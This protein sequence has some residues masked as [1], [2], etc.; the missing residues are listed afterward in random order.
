MANQKI[1]KILIFGHSNIGDIC[2]DLVVV[3]PLRI[4]F[5][6]AKISFVTSPKGMDIANTIK[7]IDQV[8]IFDKHGK[9]KGLFGYL[10][11]VGLIRKYKFDLAII[12]RGMQMHYFLGIPQSIKFKKKSRS[13]KDM[14]IAEKYLK[15]LECLGIKIEK[16]EFEFKFSKNDLEYVKQVDNEYKVDSG[17]R[18]G[19]MPLAAWPLKC[20]PIENWNEL[21]EKLVGQMNAKIFLLGRTGSSEWD[22]QIKHKISDKAVSLID[23]DNV[24]QA[25]AFIK[26]LDIFIAPDTSLL[27][28]AS[29]MGIETIG[30]Y[31]ATEV[32]FFYPLFHKQ[33]ILRSK[34]DLACMPCYPGPNAGSCHANQPAKCMQAI[35]P[36]AVWDKINEIIQRRQNYQHPLG[37][38]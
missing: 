1:R 27:H 25:M 4:A 32:D 11:F 26:T 21:I 24:S 37:K 7:G 30:L 38:I 12:L 6:E 2:Y 8:I 36:I 10:R 5:P 29:C 34:A 19:M 15:L 17:L 28:S 14:H 16:A 33:N 23:R 18:I 20:W 13:L 35:S 31:G 3:K 9:E 22:K